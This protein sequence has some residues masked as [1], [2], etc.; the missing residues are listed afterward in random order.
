MTKHTNAELD[1]ANAEKEL[2]AMHHFLSVMP[3]DP[4]PSLPMVVRMGAVIA[5][6]EERE[7]G[8]VDVET[9]TT[10][11]VV[12][13][14][15]PTQAPSSSTEVLTNSFGLILVELD[16]LCVGTVY[17]ATKA[18]FAFPDDAVAFLRL[19]Q[20]ENIPQH[21]DVTPQSMHVVTVDEERFLPSHD[22]AAA[23]R[24]A[25]IDCVIGAW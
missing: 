3:G 23:F 9:T 10:K 25:Q 8:V 16:I 18:R 17:V 21:E 12:V 13:R 20:H 22:V 7:R 2:L 6:L 5:R 1:L 15:A 14:D 19:Y 11:D 24:I 4:G